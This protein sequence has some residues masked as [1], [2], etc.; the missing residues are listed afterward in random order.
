MEPVTALKRANRRRIAYVAA[1]G[2]SCLVFVGFGI[3]LANAQEFP[4]F[5]SG[6]DGSDGALDL[7]DREPGT[8]VELG[9]SV[10][11]DNVYHYSTIVIPAQVTVKLSSRRLGT[12]PVYWLA[13]GSVT[14]GGTIDLDGEVGHPPGGGVVNALGGAGGFPGGVAQQNGFGPGGGVVTTVGIRGG[15]HVSVYGNPFLQPLIGGSG[16]AGSVFA[17]GSGREGGGGAGGGALLIASSASIDLSGSILARG[18]AAGSTDIWIGG[19]SGGAVRLLS[20]RISGSGSIS[21]AGGAG[22]GPG[23]PGRV[24]LEAYEL[25]V[26]G[27]ITAGTSRSVTLTP[28]TSILPTTAAP[29]MRVT[30]IAGQP[31]PANPLGNFAMPDLTFDEAAEVTVEIEARNVPLGTIANVA[32]A[33]ET[34]ALLTVETTPLAGTV[35][36]STATAQVRFPNGF[37]RIFASATVPPAE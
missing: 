34:D 31:V 13:S 24:R 32:V 19:G 29:S 18:G 14:I 17:V 33:N 22:S 23:E 11:G 36:L 21:T 25:A 30:R 20:P 10:D 35:E 6:S 15:K 1:V 26:S 16:G 4:P 12:S 9:P 28:T 2:G 37:T 8:I 3:W 27:V 5:D 7:S